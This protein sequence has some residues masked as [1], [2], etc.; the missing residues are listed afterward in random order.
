MAELKDSKINGNLT[1][2]GN[3]NLS[4]SSKI[5]SSIINYITD[6]ELKNLEVLNNLKA[7]K[8]VLLGEIDKSTDP[9]IYFTSGDNNTKLPNGRGEIILLE[10]TKAY[11][12]YKKELEDKS[13]YQQVALDL[14]TL[15]NITSILKSFTS[16]YTTQKEKE[17]DIPINLDNFMSN[18][19]LNVYINGILATNNIDYYFLDTF[20]EI[21]LNKAIPINSIITFQLLKNV[22]D[23][24]PK[25]EIIDLGTF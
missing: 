13:S 20:K 2:T 4:S 7:D 10:S 14:T 17:Y 6:I 18:D 25:D 5:S 1:I 8:L 19:V 11:L 24:I 22:R 3:L 23:Y 9:T 15:D 12:I 16:T 21:H